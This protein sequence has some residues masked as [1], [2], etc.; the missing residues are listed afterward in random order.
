MPFK[1][2]NK[3]NPLGGGAK[4]HQQKR[5]AEM[6]LGPHQKLAVATIVDILKSTNPDD[7]NSRLGAAKIVLEYVCGKPTQDVELSGKEGFNITV[8]LSK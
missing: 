6:L 7:V 2:G 3:A 1:P 5:L 8:H 4:G